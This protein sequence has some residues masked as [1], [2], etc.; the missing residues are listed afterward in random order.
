MADT[1]HLWAV[2][3]DDISKATAARE[4]IIKLGWGDGEAGKSLF[5]LDIAI[6]TRNADGSF[7]LDREPF[8]GVGNILSCSAVGFLA[9]LVVAA[10]LSGA[11]VGAFVGGAGTLAWATQSGINTDFI[12]DVEKMMQPGTSTLFILD[13][14]GDMGAVLHAIRGLGGTVLKTNVDVER[15]T[16]IQSTLAG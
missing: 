13:R 11:I 15:A 9:G 16:L 4:E 7:R 6:V 14:E 12:Q 5:L 1:A 10:P 3:Y 2:A 8:P